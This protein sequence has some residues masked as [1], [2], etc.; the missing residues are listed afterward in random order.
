MASVL[1]GLTKMS[2]IFIC[3]IHRNSDVKTLGHFDNET[4][5][6]YDDVTLEKL[7]H[8]EYDRRALRHWIKNPLGYLE[9]I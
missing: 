7:G 1:Q 5:V 2:S 3:K 6:Y 8:G 4:L 9:Y